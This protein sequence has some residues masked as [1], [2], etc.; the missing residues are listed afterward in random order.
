MSPTLRRDASRPAHRTRGWKPVLLVLLIAPVTAEY[1]IGYD[2]TLG[3]P[4]ALI[5]GLLVFGPIY[6]APAVLVRETA[7]RAGRGWPTMLLLATAF[8]L[9]QAG[10]IDQS[11]F[12][13]DYREIPYWQDLRVPTYLPW[14]GTSAY[15][16]LTFVTG[17]VFGSICAP[18]A[19]AEAW[20]PDRRTE[21]WLGRRGLGVMAL[22][23]ACAAVFLIA[24]QF[25]SSDFRIS[26]AQL[27]GTS[28]VVLALMTLALTRPRVTGTVPGWCPPPVIVALTTCALLIVRSV[29]G[30]TWLPTIAALAAVG[31]WV[32]LMGRWSRTPGWS[33]R[34]VVAALAGNLVS[35][36][37]PAF[38]TTPLGDVPAATKYVMNT[39]LLTIV[40]AVAA[41][42]YRE[43]SR[44]QQTGTSA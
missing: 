23:W 32:V 33:G 10:L 35:I 38:F 3:Q 24:D 40:L 25:S 18:I 20:W 8:G 39:V 2:D 13:P 9:I 43:E 28:L 31:V 41:R 42:A 11:L 6:G 14:A 16:L 1:L 15:M 12:A 27:A 19:M 17:H 34:H 4:A 26:P 21:P 5:F 36:G 44:W 29:V 37:G 22:L 30:T 7:R